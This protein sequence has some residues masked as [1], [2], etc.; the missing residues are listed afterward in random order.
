MSDKRIRP[1]PIVDHGHLMGII[2]I[3]DVVNHIISEQ[4][5]T[6]ADLE[7]YVSGAMYH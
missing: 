5:Q 4:K 3:G 6:I 2:T 7:S 1:L